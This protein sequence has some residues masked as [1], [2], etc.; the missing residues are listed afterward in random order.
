MPFVKVI[1]DKAYFKRFQVKFARRRSGHTDYAARHKLITQDK[2]K[3]GSPKYRLVVRFSNQY[4][5][6]QVISSEISGD[7]VICEAS[8]AELPRYGLK[9][10]LK[11]FPAA[12]CTGLLCARRLLA[13]LKL[14][15]MYPGV[16]EVDGTVNVFNAYGMEIEEKARCN[17]KKF[18]VEGAEE[19]DRKP[20]RAYLDVGIKTTSRGA[21]VFSAMKGASDGGMDIPHN[22]KKFP[23]YDPDVKSYDPDEFKSRI[24]GGHIAEYME[25]MEEDDEENFKKVF[26]A[27]LENDIAA[28]DMEALYETVHDAI[29]ENPTHVKG[30]TFD[31]DGKQS[32]FTY[33]KTGKEIKRQGKLTYEQRR[34]AS[35]AKKAALNEE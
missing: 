20:F 30:R 33:T 34:A 25:M 24:M 26:A 18:Y 23:G 35:N 32:A 8:S 1:K 4:V 11:N 29:R 21:K 12:Y 22:H 13:D 2:N 16:K 14:D 31:D 7:R 19:N 28:D 5:R 9:V 17:S 3:Y 27:Y 6:V 15:E 10:G